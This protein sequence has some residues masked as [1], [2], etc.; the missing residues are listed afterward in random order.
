[1]EKKHN[2]LRQDH[3]G[4]ENFPHELDTSS[5]SLPNGQYTV[6]VRTQMMVGS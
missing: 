5:G 2:I 3:K 1:M 6:P 4:T